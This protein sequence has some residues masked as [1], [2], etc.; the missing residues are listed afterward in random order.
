MHYTSYNLK[1]YQF[2]LNKQLHGGSYFIL[3]NKNNVGKNKIF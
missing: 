3:M 2:N 1:F